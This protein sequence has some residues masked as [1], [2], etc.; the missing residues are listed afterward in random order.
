MVAGVGIWAS[1]QA[2]HAT[3]GARGARSVFSATSSVLRPP[4]ST[5]ALQRS[6]IPARSLVALGGCTG[7]WVTSRKMVPADVPGQATERSAPG[8]G[9]L[10]VDGGDPEAEGWFGPVMRLLKRLMWTPCVVLGAQDRGGDAASSTPGCR[11]PVI[12]RHIH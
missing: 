9:G 2:V 11:P 4:S 6:A 3:H 7:F 8:W 1:G 12:Q 5:C 10:S